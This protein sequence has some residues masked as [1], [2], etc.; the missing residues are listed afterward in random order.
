MVSSQLRIPTRGNCCVWLQP[1]WN[2]L[3]RILRQIGIAFGSCLT[4]SRQL[5][6]LQNPG[7]WDP[8]A[9]SYTKRYILTKARIWTENL[10]AGGNWKRFYKPRRSRSH[11]QCSSIHESLR[12][13][14]T[15]AT[16]GF[17]AEK[18]ITT[19]SQFWGPQSKNLY[20]LGKG[21]KKR[22]IIKG[23]RVAVPGLEWMGWSS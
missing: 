17:M 13:Y 2:K 15:F 7:I 3:R 12:G 11:A 16:I 5:F 9:E 4:E 18:T 14:M 20:I 1:S 10:E 8:N 19:T 22:I 21:L 23:C 6:K